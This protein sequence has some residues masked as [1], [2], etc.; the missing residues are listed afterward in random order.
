MLK[1]PFLVACGLVSVGLAFVGMALPVLPTV[2]FL[3]VAVACFARSSPRLLDWLLGNRIFGPLQRDWQ[4]N[5][6]VPTQAKI[7]GMATIV[8]VGFF[9]VRS[10]G[11][12]YLK[13]LVTLLLVVPFVILLRA[14]SSRV[15][16]PN[17]TEDS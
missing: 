8:V 3:L 1:R 11:T 16:Q 2:P 12:I 13:I 10:M 6:T 5:R 9:S 17:L 4:E 7:L 15:G 14:K